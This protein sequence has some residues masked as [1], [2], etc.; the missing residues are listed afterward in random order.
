MN[1]SAPTLAPAGV[2]N[3]FSARLAAAVQGGV[4]LLGVSLLWG[5]HLQRRSDP[6]IFLFS[7]LTSAWLVFPTGALIGTVVPGWV[8][9]RAVASAAVVGLG[10][11][12]A[13]GLTLACGIWITG[14]HLDLIGLLANRHSGG[15]ASYSYS[16]KQQLY[17]QAMSALTHTA[18][19]AAAWVLGWT[20]WM[21]L[22]PRGARDGNFAAP[23]GV[24]LQFDRRLWYAIGSV[25]GVLAVVGLAALLSTSLF[26]RGAQVPLG[27]F[28]I[29]PPGAAGLVLLGPFLGPLLTHNSSEWAWKYAAVSIPVLMATLAPFA[30]CRKPLR[31]S[32]AVVIWCGFITALL[33]WVATG[34][35]SLGHCIG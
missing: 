10:F 4:V 5:S 17:Q 34:L 20:I 11:G 8:R 16:V 12:L 19:V 9:G 2:R 14:S 35:Y 30:L 1:S 33:L 25:A 32:F 27:S 22:R 24:T 28:L 3:E 6:F 15:Y 21:N 7:W 26:K 31:P 13:V 23:A 29:V 18:P